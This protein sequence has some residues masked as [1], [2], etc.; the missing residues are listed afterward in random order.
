[1]YVGIDLALPG[2]R[3][4]GFGTLNIIN[5]TYYVRTLS[6]K[7]E[8]VEMTLMNN[9]KLVCI[10]AP[11]G[12]PR[13]GINRLIEVKARERGLRLIPPLLG[14]MREL[15]NYGIE[16]ASEL[17]DRGINVLEC[18]PTSTLKVLNMSKQEF[19]ALITSVFRGPMVNNKHELDAL[20]AAFTCLLH[21]HGCTEELIGYEGEGSLI[22]PRSDCE[23]KVIING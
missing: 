17:R 6:N 18:H 15:T 12:L 2:K 1:M 10:D 19:L 8:V 4:T 14:P 13:Y 16:I 21:S 23:P 9:P 5:H 20:V 11:L 3:R 7:K 22:I